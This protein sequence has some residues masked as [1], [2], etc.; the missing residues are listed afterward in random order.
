VYY[1]G[2]YLH[3][4]FFSLLISTLVFGGW[5][6]PR[7][8]L[9][10]FLNYFSTEITFEQNTLGTILYDL[11]IILIDLS[12][13]YGLILYYYCPSIFDFII[14]I[15]ELYFIIVPFFLVCYL[16]SLICFVYE[17]H[18]LVSLYFFYNLWNIFI[19]SIY[20]IWGTYFVITIMYIYYNIL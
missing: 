6:F 11:D 17:M 5:E 18:M 2:E 9:I 14:W 13:A 10:V 7:F 20:N 12:P 3:L 4:F 1:L 15:Y 19:N 16:D 8:L